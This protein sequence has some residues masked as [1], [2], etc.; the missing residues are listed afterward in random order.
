MSSVYLMESLSNPL[1][2]SWYR[3]SSL[4]RCEESESISNVAILVEKDG[5]NWR[6]RLE[7]ADSHQ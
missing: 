4:L 2:G 1:N 6:L 7:H 3:Y 5:T